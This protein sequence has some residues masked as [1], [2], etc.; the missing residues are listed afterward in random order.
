[1][2]H[3]KSQLK[4]AMPVYQGATLKRMYR[5]IHRNDICPCGSG[6]KFKHCECF[7]KYGENRGYFT[8]EELQEYVKQ[9]SNGEPS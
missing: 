2:S 5:K 6:K 4:G 1:M 7:E 9:F 3:K 8:E